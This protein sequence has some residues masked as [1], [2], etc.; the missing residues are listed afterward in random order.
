MASNDHHIH[1]YILYPPILR[2]FLY[3]LK[4]DTFFVSGLDTPSFIKTF[5]VETVGPACVETRVETATVMPVVPVIFS[6][7]DLHGLPKTLIINF[8]SFFIS[9]HHPN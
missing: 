5:L 8:L 4:I 2:E 3:H 6:F 1:I 9:F 7:I